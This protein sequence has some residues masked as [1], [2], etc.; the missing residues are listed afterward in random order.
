MGKLKILIVEDHAIVREALKQLIDASQQFT[1]I[2]ETADGDNV[3]ELC[4]KSKADIVLM[5]LALPTIDGA[6][7]TKALLDANPA[8]K[9]V[10]LTAYED[11][12]HIRKCLAAGAKGYVFK[13]SVSHELYTALSVVAQGGAYI[14]KFASD[15]LH[16]LFDEAS[17]PEQSLSEREGQVIK[18]V[19]R[20]MSA[21]EIGSKLGISIKTVDT[22]KTRALEKL[23][24][25]SR[26]ELVQY[27]IRCGWL[28]SS[29]E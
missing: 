29:M 7:C 14:D 27:A 10:V 22:Y 25:A 6:A 24:L 16:D 8:I 15:K 28:D 9:V 17:L 2:A 26:A 20:G 1:V 23:G 18:Q 3:V 11:L 12:R 4:S 19:A 5:D 21:K 13:R